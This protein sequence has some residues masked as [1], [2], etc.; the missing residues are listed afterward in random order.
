MGRIPISTA[1]PFVQVGGQTSSIGATCS[2]PERA[3]PCS[4]DGTGFGESGEQ[5]T[6]RGAIAVRRSSAVDDRTSP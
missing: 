3:I 2:S 5:L 4:S 1:R 6:E